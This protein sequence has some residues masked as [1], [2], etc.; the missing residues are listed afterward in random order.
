MNVAYSYLLVLLGSRGTGDD[1]ARSRRLYR[2]QAATL[3]FAVLAPLAGSAIYNAGLG[4]F[5]QLDLAPFTFTLTSLAFFSGFL[6]F[7]VL[8]LLPVARDAI[9]EGM[10]DG[11]LVLDAQDRLV[12]LN[13]AAQHILGFRVR[14]ATGQPAAHLFANHPD[15][16]RLCSAPGESRAEVDL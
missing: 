11:V 10:R 4:P 15:L 2:Q 1:L 3:V 6:R 5:P 13:P 12:D 16:L 7:R 14:P 9:L 8:D